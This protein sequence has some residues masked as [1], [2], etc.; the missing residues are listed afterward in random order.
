MIPAPGEHDGEDVHQRYEVIKSGE[1]RGLGGELYYGYRPDLLGE[2]TRAFSES[3]YPIE[4]NNVH[5]IK[6]LVQDTM[7]I[8]GPVS[9]AHIDVDWYE[10]VL[11]C[12]QR[13]VPRLSD[14]GAIVLDDYKDWSG[15]RQATDDY[16]SDK[17]SWDFD[18]SGSSLVVR[19]R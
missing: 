9:L 1:S 3:G 18:L 19:R 6:G 5:L 4:Q 14:G 12:L 13:I 8:D 16:F 17:S 15:C 7:Q 2:V 11:T 10:P